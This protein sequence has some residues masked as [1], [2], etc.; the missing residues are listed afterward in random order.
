MVF[1]LLGYNTARLQQHT[2]FSPLQDVI[3]EFDFYLHM[4]LSFTKNVLFLLVS[5]D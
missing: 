4:Y 2:I 3:T 1:I 5:T